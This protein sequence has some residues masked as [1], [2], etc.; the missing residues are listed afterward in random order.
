[1]K[2]IGVTVISFE[3]RLARV[4]NRTTTVEMNNA[5]PVRALMLSR[6]ACLSS[7]L[8]LDTADMAENTSGAPLPKARRV[9]PA[10]D[11]DKPNLMVINSK[12]GD[13]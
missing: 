11:S 5:D 7:G 10:K 9:T 13:K 3:G 2:K 6:V 12:D 4:D 8:A 1:M